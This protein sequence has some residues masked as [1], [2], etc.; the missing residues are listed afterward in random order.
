MELIILAT[1]PSLEAGLSK[2]NNG[3]DFSYGI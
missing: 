3:Y 1:R 2:K